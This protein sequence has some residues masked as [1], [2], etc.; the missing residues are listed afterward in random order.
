MIL[1]YTVIEYI[2][3]YNLPFRLIDTINGAASIALNPLKNKMIY[4]RTK[5]GTYNI[6]Y[7]HEDFMWIFYL[8]SYDYFSISKRDDN[9]KT[10]Q[11]Y[12]L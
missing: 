6:L 5:E 10:I 7:E 4:I 8:P 3:A 12:Q 1:D 2:D 9:T 11:R